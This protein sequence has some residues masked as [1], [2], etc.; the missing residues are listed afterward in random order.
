MNILGQTRVK[1]N[2]RLLDHLIPQSRR[3]G[4]HR[5][6]KNKPNFDSKNQLKCDVVTNLHEF[7]EKITKV[8]SNNNQDLI[9]FRGQRESDKKLVPKIGR[10][11]TRLKGE[12]RSELPEIEERFL[13]LFKRLSL[14]FIETKPESNSEWL[15]IAQHHGLPTRLLDWTANALAALWFVVRKEAVKNKNGAVWV[16]N[17][18]DEDFIPSDTTRELFELERIKV[19]RPRHVTKRL[20]VQSG[21]FTV[22]PWNQIT[23]RFKSLNEDLTLGTRLVEIQ[24]DSNSFS[25]FRDNL[26]RLGISDLTMFPDLDGICRYIAW[27]NSLLADEQDPPNKLLNQTEWPEK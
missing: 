15:A 14:P 27:N 22:H 9:L 16:L 3:G 5:A 8:K 12:N 19:Y 7:V 23:S 25:N 2:N 24:I 17:P 18:T 20:I 13:E 6:Q 4:S 1:L 26:E 11:E 10:K 21:Y